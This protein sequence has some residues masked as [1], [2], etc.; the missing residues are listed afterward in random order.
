MTSILLYTFFI[1]NELF[2]HVENTKSGDMVKKKNKAGTFYGEWYLFPTVLIR[3]SLKQLDSHDHRLL[4][5][6]IPL[7]L[8]DIRSMI[9]SLNTDSQ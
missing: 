2:H 8:L 6:Y 1:L 4:Y 5:I 3:L 9:D 7:P